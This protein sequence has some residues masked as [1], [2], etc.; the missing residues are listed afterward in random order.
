MRVTVKFKVPMTKNGQLRNPGD[1]MEIDATQATLLAK[2][3]VVEIPGF[4]IAQETRPVVFDI[5]V[6]KEE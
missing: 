2:R 6:P 5:L 3:G 4:E 1:T